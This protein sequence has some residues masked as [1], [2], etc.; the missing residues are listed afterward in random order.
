MSVFEWGRPT[1]AKLA[2]LPDIGELEPY[3]WDIWSHTWAWHAVR[4]SRDERAV[5]DARLGLDDARRLRRLL[6]A[7]Q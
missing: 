2:G 5:F 7:V 4:A 3:R 1:H 6:S